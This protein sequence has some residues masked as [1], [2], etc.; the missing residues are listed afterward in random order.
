MT[1][2]DAILVLML[3]DRIHGSDEAVRRAGKNIV[4]KLPRSKRDIIYE[5]ISSPRP[6]ELIHHIALHID[7]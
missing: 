5:L 4:K 3:A 6:K 2:S 7:D 1:L